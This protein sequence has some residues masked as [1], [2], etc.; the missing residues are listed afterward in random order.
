MP[1]SPVTPQSVV[2]QV[3][4]P[5]GFSRQEY[6]SGLPFP[7]PRH[8]LHPGIKPTSPA[9]GGG[10]FTSEPPGKP[11][12]LVIR[13]H[14]ELFNST[15]CKQPN[16]K[17]GK[18]LKWASLVAQ[19]V[20]NLPAIRGHLGSIPGLG[21]SPGEGKGYPLQYSRLENS[22]DCIAKGQ[23]RPSTF[24]FHHENSCLLTWPMRTSRDLASA[25]PL[26]FQH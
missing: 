17:L 22:M 7:S 21:K 5:T 25:L 2:C 6:W 14:K 19:L 12:D 1:D 16:L 18:G 26:Q 10:F 20:K 4:L 3:L 13:I 24:H 11:I 15:M 9:I 23:I 8:L